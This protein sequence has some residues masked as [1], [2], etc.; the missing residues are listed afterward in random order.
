MH[1]ELQIV[2]DGTMA[3]CPHQ[4]CSHTCCDF[5]NDN[6]IALYPGEV[7]KAQ[8]EAKSLAHLDVVPDGSGGHRAICR[9]HDKASCDNGYKPLDCASYPLFPSVGPQRRLVVVLKGS[10][11]PLQMEDLS[12]HHT[13]VESR[14]T[15]LCGSVE[16]LEAWLDSV[17]LVG[18]EQTTDPRDASRGKLNSASKEPP[19]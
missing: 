15:Q 18:Y 9:A 6:F 17:Q 1:S 13:W 10:K 2:S 4:G 12:T 8:A 14:W 16:G 3:L 19:I 11:C 7:A 5:A